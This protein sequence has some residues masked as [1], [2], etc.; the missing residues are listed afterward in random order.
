MAELRES[1]AS[2]SGSGPLS[3]GLYWVEESN[4]RWSTLHWSG[5]DWRGLAGERIA[6]ECRAMAAAIAPARMPGV[7][8]AEYELPDA[9]PI[10]RAELRGLLALAGASLWCRQNA[11]AFAATPVP[12]DVSRSFAWVVE[13]HL[14]VPDRDSSLATFGLVIA[15]PCSVDPRVAS[16]E[17]D[18]AIHAACQR[19]ASHE[20]A[21]GLLLGGR[22]CYDPHQRGEPWTWGRGPGLIAEPLPRESAELSKNRQG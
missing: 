8:A 2:G 3:P 21:E 14:L 4:G 9:L 1:T 10:E 7:S 17:A 20:A 13:V 22:R 18:A 19:A 12:W 16:P 15:W 5:V 6:L 11:R